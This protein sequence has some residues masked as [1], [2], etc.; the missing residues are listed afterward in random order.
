M[1][2]IQ[3]HPVQNALAG[4]KE[5]LAIVRGLDDGA[6][7]VGR[8]AAADAAKGQV[9][10]GFLHARPVGLGRGLPHAPVGKQVGFAQTGQI[11]D[12][13]RAPDG[14]AIAAGILLE[15]GR[16]GT[17]GDEPDQTGQNESETGQEGELGQADTQPHGSWQVA[18]PPGSVRPVHGLGHAHAVR[19]LGPGRRPVRKRT[20]L[21]R[22][23]ALRYT[24]RT[25]VL[26][27]FGN[28]RVTIST[29]RTER[30][31]PPRY[32]LTRSG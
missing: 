11:G 27:R 14:Q 12:I 15:I 4:R 6:A 25:S 2:F 5:A 17:K 26:R 22:E 16:T 10:L 30:P 8:G 19:P 1:H 29:G 13:G 32:R 21:W 9:E 7:T 20:G 23:K 31:A 28:I 18:T 24:R 3:P